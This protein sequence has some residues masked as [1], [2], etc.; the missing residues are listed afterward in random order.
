MF[1]SNYSECWPSGSDKFLI[2]I[3]PTTRSSKFDRTAETMFK[4]EERQLQYSDLKEDLIS[5]DLP[6]LQELCVQRRAVRTWT[7]TLSEP[8]LWQKKW[9]FNCKKKKGKNV[10]FSSLQSAGSGPLH[11]TPSTDDSSHLH[12]VAPF[13]LIFTVYSPILLP[14]YLFLIQNLI[15]FELKSATLYFVLAGSC[16]HSVQANSLDCSV[17]FMLHGHLSDSALKVFAC[18]LV[19]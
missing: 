18:L 10:L 5:C 2:L 11:D 19:G 7:C 15:T 14:S 6:S 3:G 12:Q 16:L 8:L 13:L 1:Y 17:A 4:E 9:F